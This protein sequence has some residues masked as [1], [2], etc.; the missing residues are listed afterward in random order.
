MFGSAYRRELQHRLM[1]NF[2]LRIRMHFTDKHVEECMWITTY[3]KLHTEGLLLQKVVV[4][5]SL[6]KDF[7]KV[8]NN[9]WN[10]LQ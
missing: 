2:K 7:K 10:F 4:N 8:L 5:I 3:T 1:K 9:E 6:M